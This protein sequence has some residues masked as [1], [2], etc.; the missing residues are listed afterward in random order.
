VSI[1]VSVV[2]AA[3]IAWTTRGLGIAIGLTGPGTAHGI[4]DILVIERNIDR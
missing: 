2:I 3:D 1:I 4:K